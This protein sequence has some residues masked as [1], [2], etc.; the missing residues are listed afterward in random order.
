MIQKCEND[1]ITTEFIARLPIID[2]TNANRKS[3]NT[4]KLWFCVKI[5]TRKQYAFWIKWND[6]WYEK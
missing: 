3:W 5:Y 4:L 2:L 1:V 6:K